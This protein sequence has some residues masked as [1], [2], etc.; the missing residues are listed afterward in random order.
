MKK[1]TMTAEEMERLFDDGDERYLEYFD[2]NKAT[3]PG[4]DVKKVNVSLP[5]V[6]HY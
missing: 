6:G 2:L 5:S 1:E 3:R 4:L